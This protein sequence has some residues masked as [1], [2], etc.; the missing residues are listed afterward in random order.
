MTSQDWFEKDFYAVLGVPASAD[1]PAIKRAYRKL[2]R[3]LHPDQRPGDAA[4]EARFKEI[5]EAYAVLSKPQE[6]GQ[7]DELRAMGAA[8]ARFAPAG[9]AGFDDAHRNLFAGDAR[10][11][12]GRGEQVSFE[13]LLGGVFI[14]QGDGTFARPGRAGEHVH[15]AVTLS[16][17]DAVA[18]AAVTLSR[19]DGS[20]I[21]CRI[22]AG[23][24][25][26]QK[27]RL[28]GKGGPGDPAGDLL[29]TVQVKAHPVFGRVGDNVTVDLPLTFAEAALGATV[30]VPT[31][32]GV[33]VRVRI[34][35]GTP[36]GRVLRVKGRGVQGEGRTGDLLVKVSVLVPGRLSAK[37]R[38][39]VQV[40]A[41]QE[42]GLDPRAG[43]FARAQEG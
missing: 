11:A 19:P 21:T 37:A 31:L 39:A 16:F 30:A 22:P 40:L 10:F 13:D 32:S 18:G 24:R 23:V 26:G 43:V 25:D 20:Q 12:A 28:R 36:A 1:G 38:A 29:L 5:G 6:R 41:E 34:A 33:P 2:A 8:G 15:A 4:A 14:Q 3:G 7:Y 35:A 27:I 42:A 9:G 17:R